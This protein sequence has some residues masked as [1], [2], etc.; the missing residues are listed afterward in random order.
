M[1]S[2]Q[3]KRR[4]GTLPS[5]LC[6][7]C[8]LTAFVSCSDEPLFDDESETASIKENSIEARLKKATTWQEQIEILDQKMRRF[9]N[10]KV[11]IAQGYTELVGP[12][13]EAG[14]PYVPN[15]GYHY[16]NPELL[17]DGFNLLEP[18]ILVYYPDED[19]N[20]IFG[21]AEYLE[22]IPNF[23][24]PSGCKNDGSVPAPEGFIGDADH[25]L[26]NC[27]A[28]GWTLHAWVGTENPDGV[29][30]HSNP[31]VPAKDVSLD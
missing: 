18:E 1:K 3:R 12:P 31:L 22:E 28:G 26:D 24:P 20:M 4:K 25:W 23:A 21:A 27:G 11:A 14:G 2:L 8:L 7:L 19:G 30:A 6:S 13:P 9:H 10:F 16:R 15:M 17:D 29:F 5:F